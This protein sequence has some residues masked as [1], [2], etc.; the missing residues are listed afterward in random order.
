[1]HPSQF[2]LVRH[3]YVPMK[4]VSCPPP[5]PHSVISY[6]VRNRHA[7]FVLLYFL[8]TSNLKILSILG[9]SFRFSFAVSNTHCHRIRDGGGVS[10]SPTVH[11]RTIEVTQASWKQNL[12]KINILSRYLENIP[13]SRPYEQFSQK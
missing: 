4:E 7:L 12:L 10:P 3:T 9:F 6:F 13:I 11:F 8:E 5:P 1:M 2:R